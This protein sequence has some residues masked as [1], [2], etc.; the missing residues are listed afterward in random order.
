MT[1]AQRVALELSVEFFYHAAKIAAFNAG[2]AVTHSSNE[3]Q[4]NNGW[5]HEPSLD[6]VFA[7]GSEGYLS[8]SGFWPL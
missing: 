3:G 2:G 7:D 4:V 5:S 8:C 6:Y 1:Q